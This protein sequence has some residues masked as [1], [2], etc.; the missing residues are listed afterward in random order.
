MRLRA[1][2]TLCAGLLLLASC[3]T[4]NVD[5]CAG[6]EPVQASAES[7]EWL[8]ANDARALKAMIGHAEFGRAMKCWK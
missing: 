4:P 2:L 1:I 6:W 7:V 5:R 8:A 3:A